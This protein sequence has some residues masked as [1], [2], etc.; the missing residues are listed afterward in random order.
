M[1]SSTPDHP[2]GATAPTG[3]DFPPPSPPVQQYPAA[4]TS[5]GGPVPGEPGGFK[6][7]FGMGTGLGL[8]L[9]ATIVVISVIGGI[10]SVISLGMLVSTAS[11]D[12]SASTAT[13]T[14]WGD[15]GASSTLRAIEVSGAIMTSGDSGGLFATGTYGY[16]VADMFDDLDA[17]DADGVVLLVDTPGG[18]ITGSKAISDA[19]VRYQDRTGHKV[20]VHVQGTS[21]SGG[22][23]STAPADVI[24]ADHGSIIGSIGIIYGPFTRYNDVIATSGSILESGVT[25]TGGITQEYLT[26][27]TGKDFGNPFRDIEPAERQMIEDILQAEYERFVDHVVAH[28][29]IA[30]S[31]IVDEMGAG[32]FEPGRAEELGLVDGTLGRDE[33]FR[34]AATLAGLDPDDT[35]VVAPSGPTGLEALFGVERA[36]GQALPISVPDAGQAVLNAGICGGNAPLVFAGDLASVCR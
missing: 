19:I 17:D 9:L 35:A 25:T 10:F 32:V 26:R 16:E 29:G 14:I 36:F 1:S 31:V 33:F 8:G 23:Y 21:A 6:R 28:R 11:G 18:T 30:A 3:T 20:M 22:V 12:S 15:S 34:E 27:G 4:G 5:P 24:Y 7:G 13:Q 2:T